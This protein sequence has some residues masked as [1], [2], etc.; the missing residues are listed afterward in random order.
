[1]CGNIEND[2]KQRI[3]VAVK[4]VVVKAGKALIVRRSDWRTPDGRDWWEFPGGT[5]LFRETPEQTLV[6]EMQ[7]ET[8][9]TVAS[10]KLLYVWSVERPS[11]CQVIII[12]YLC[13]C[14]NESEVTLSDE[15]TGYVWADAMQMRELLADDIKEAL[16]AN[17]VWKIFDTE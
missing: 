7:E 2:E 4:G 11:E 12:T 10:G 6:R 1:M 13:D 9:L 16:D 3:F 8:G 5:L 15:H 14:G 17:D